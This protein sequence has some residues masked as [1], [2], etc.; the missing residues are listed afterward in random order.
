MDSSLRTVCCCKSMMTPIDTDL[1]RMFDIGQPVFRASV[2]P[3]GRSLG[4]PDTLN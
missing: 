2:V 3:L 1:T 4:L